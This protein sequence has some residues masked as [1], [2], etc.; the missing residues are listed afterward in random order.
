MYLAQKIELK[1]N[2]ELVNAF[3]QSFG[4]SR[5]IYNKALETWN[6]MYDKYLEDNSNPKPNHRKVRD[7]LKHSKEDWEESQLKMILDTSCED[8]GK[9][10]NMMWKG[11]GKY[12]RFKKKNKSRNSFRMYRKNDYSIQIKDNKYL[13]IPGLKA[14]IKMKED[15]KIDGI[16]KEVTI[17]EKGHKYYASFVLEVDDDY[18]DKIDNQEFVGIDLGI[19]SLAIINGTD[20]LFKKYHSLNKKLIP[21]YKKI[22]YYNK[23]LSRKCYKSNNYEKVRTKLNRT[24]LRIDNIKK[25]YL[26]KITTNL[27]VRYKYI[28]IEDL[29]V[30]NLIKNKRLSK[31]ISQ[32]N[33]RMFRSMLEYK[34]EMYG[35]E[36]IVADKCFPSSQTCSHCGNVLTKKKKIK[37]S[38]RTYK[39]KKCGFIID[40]DFNAAINLKL[41]GE[42]FVG[43]AN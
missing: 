12:P 37:L 15:L 42:R 39:C 31:Y 19:K 43:V 16:I 28:C 34:A 30:S 13:K 29:K 38:Q 10:F 6:N 9:A 7:I 36:I 32:Q 23:V 17:S 20:G 4:Y 3:Q 2:K 24:Y 21:L 11:H 14:L 8:L 27:C 1:P 25:D 22:D 18:Y 33:W 41:Y 5:Y 26:H 40:R 35:N